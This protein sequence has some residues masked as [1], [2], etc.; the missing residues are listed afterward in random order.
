MFWGL[1][2]PTFGQLTKPVKYIRPYSGFTQTLWSLYVGSDTSPLLSRLAQKG[3][4]PKVPHPQIQPGGLKIF[5][6]KK[7]KKKDCVCTEHGQTFFLFI[8]PLTI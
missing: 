6:K 1:F 5:W 7:K 4:C 8:I 2:A 3:Q